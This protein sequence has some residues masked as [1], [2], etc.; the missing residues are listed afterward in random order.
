MVEVRDSAMR[1]VW[2]SQMLKEG[3]CEKWP[4]FTDISRGIFGIILPDQQYLGNLM[5][6]THLKYICSKSGTIGGE[7]IRGRLL[8]WEETGAEEEVDQRRRG[9]NKH[10]KMEIKRGSC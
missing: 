1:D 10:G 3:M 8:I 7:V 9:K 5:R 4:N 2:V 6:T